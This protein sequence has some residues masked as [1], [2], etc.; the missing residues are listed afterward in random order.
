[1]CDPHTQVRCV[2]AS[3]SR[4]FSSLSLAHTTGVEEVSLG[5]QLRREER[6]REAE[7]GLSSFFGL[8]RR[9]RRLKEASFPAAAA[10]AGEGFAMG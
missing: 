8:C 9:R 2:Q 1:M 5:G 10:S 7:M 4:I 6:E 3:I